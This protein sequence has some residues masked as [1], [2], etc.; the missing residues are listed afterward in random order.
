MKSW[1]ELWSPNILTT[2]TS[3]I[4]AQMRYH[5]VFPA[6][7]TVT[8]NAIMASQR[9]GPVVQAGLAEVICAVPGRAAMKA[10]PLTPS[11]SIR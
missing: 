11:R 2:L 3:Q 10:A 5:D 4:F 1:G 8:W 9:T 6:I 7:T